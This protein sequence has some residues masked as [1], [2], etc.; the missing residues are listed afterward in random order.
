L[1]YPARV[2]KSAKIDGSDVEKR[3]NQIVINSLLIPAAAPIS[4]PN[5][6]AFA[7]L[8]RDKTSPQL[9]PDDQAS[10]LFEHESIISQSRKEPIF[11]VHY[12]V[13]VRIV[14]IKN[15]NIDFSS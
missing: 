13:Q 9:S 1:K 4:L 11:R 6:V 10:K 12:A 3:K 5:A 14:Y 7:T 2:I 15:I 8:P